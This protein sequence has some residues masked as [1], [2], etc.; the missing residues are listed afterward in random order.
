MALVKT[1]RTETNQNPQRDDNIEGYLNI[2]V[3]DKQG[4]EHRLSKGIPLSTLRNIDRSLLAA[5]ERDGDNFQPRVVGTIHLLN[6]E[7]EEIQF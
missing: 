1:R 4:N 2:S 3:I 6:T 7:Q 5:A